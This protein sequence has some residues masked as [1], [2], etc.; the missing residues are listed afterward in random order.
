[1]TWSPVARP[2]A[3]SCPTFS[4]I[5]T[6]A[7]PGA[8]WAAAVTS[9]LVSREPAGTVT[10]ARLPASTAASDTGIGV[11]PPDTATLA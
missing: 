10:A 11:S 1:M 8:T 6:T 9:A 2:P 5:P 3:G 7:Y 4:E